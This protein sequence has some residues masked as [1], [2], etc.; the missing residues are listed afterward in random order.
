MKA[1]FASPREARMDPRWEGYIKTTSLWRHIREAEID[2][3]GSLNCDTLRRL[4]PEALFTAALGALV[5]SR[6]DHILCC[7]LLHAAR[8]RN[9]PDAAWLV[10]KV[11]QFSSARLG[12]A[13]EGDYDYRALYMMAL[14]SRDLARRKALL[15]RGAA[16]G[17]ARAMV[18]LVDEGFVEEREDVETLLRT[19]VEKDNARAHLLWVAHGFTNLHKDMV[20]HVRR[21]ADL[22]D[23][24]AML[25]CSQSAKL[26]HQ[27]RWSTELAAFSPSRRTL[28]AVTLQGSWSGRD[29]NICFAAGR[30]LK[31]FRDVL[32][33]DPSQWPEYQSHPLAVITFFEDASKNA[34]DIVILWMWISGQIGLIHDVAII[35]GHML[36]DARRTCPQDFAQFSPN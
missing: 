24:G 16:L 19:A 3:C 4:R 17:H 34:K 30:L 36:W 15:E 13:L 14:F 27:L 21:A 25:L 35:I 11:E 22:G 28:L 8:L 2:Y 20:V 18:A 5:S 23:P 10:A 7:Q 32:T 33:R 31:R 1:F 9:C 6:R 26:D 29:F 12:L